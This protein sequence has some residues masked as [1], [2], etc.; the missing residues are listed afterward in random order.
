[1]SNQKSARIKETLTTVKRRYGAYEL[2]ALEAKGNDEIIDELIQMKGVGLK[3]ASCVLLFSMGRDVFPV[4][5][6]IHRICNRLG[7]GNGSATPEKTYSFMKSLVP[8]GMGYAFHTNLIRFGRRIC[9]SNK[10]SC[11]VCPLFDECEYEGKK[12]VQKSQRLFSRAN[13][14]FMLLDNVRAH[15]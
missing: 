13:H 1:M 7:L 2:A 3:T 14:D 9:R 8:K 11:Y 10:P 15:K 4:D 5:T 12:K 6:H